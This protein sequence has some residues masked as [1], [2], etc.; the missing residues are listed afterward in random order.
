MAQ[1]INHYEASLKREITKVYKSAFGKGPED[2]TVRVFDNI[3]FVKF[4][5]G[6]S[7][8]E[9]YLMASK[10]G[11][12]IVYKIRDEIL[13]DQSAAYFPVVEDIIKIKVEQA[14]Y[15]IGEKDSAIY[16][17]M[18]CEDNILQAAG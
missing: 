6:F 16:L 1:T 10:E 12:Q 7:P 17:C 2:T 5:G 13:I 4:V 8:V 15:T 14:R 11:A 18:I 3:I 9:Q